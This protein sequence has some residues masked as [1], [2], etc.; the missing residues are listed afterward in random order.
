MSVQHRQRASGSLSKG[1]SFVCVAG[2]S[3][4]FLTKSSKENQICLRPQRGGLSLYPAGTSLCCY[5]D[6]CRGV[7]GPVAIQNAADCREQCATE[8]GR[9]A[10]SNVTARIW[11]P[12]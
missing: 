4:E 6:L 1:K 11:P 5:S 7:I 12:T 3:P 2:T 9:R 8:R 10:E